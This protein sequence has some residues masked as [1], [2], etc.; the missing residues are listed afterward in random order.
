MLK[1]YTITLIFL[2]VLFIQALFAATDMQPTVF[3]D[4]LEKVPAGMSFEYY[5]KLQNNTGIATDQASTL[6]ITIPEGFTFQNDNGGHGCT[7][8]GA[9]PSDGNGYVECS[10]ASGFAGN[11]YQEINITVLS[12]EDAGVFKSYATV[13]YSGDTN[14][15]NNQ[16][17]TKTTIIES[18]DVELKSI[19]PT[20]TNTF[21]AGSIATF[22]L[23]IANNGP[24]ATSA[25]K[26]T[27]TLPTGLEYS[28]V[29]GASGWSCATSGADLTCERAGTFAKNTDE[30]INLNLRVTAQGGSTIP[31]AGAVS[32]SDTVVDRNR[33]NND[34]NTTIYTTDG[35]DLSISKGINDSELI[36]NTIATFT[37]SAKNNGPQGAREVKVSDTI[38]AGHDFNESNI[39]L[40]SPTDWNCS[41]VGQA[42]SCEYIGNGGEMP[43]GT[44]DTITIITTTPDVSADTDYTNTATIETNLTD[45]MSGNDSGS[46][47]YKVRVDQTDLSVSKSKKMKEDHRDGEPIL[48][49]E[50]MESS[51]SVRN[52]GPRD[53]D[54]DEVIVKDTLDANESYIGFSGSDWDCSESSG[55]VTCIYRKA[56]ANGA[57]TT[58]LKIETNATQGDVSVLNEVNVNTTNTNYPD[59]TPSN[60]NDSDSMEAQEYP[61]SADIEVIKTRDDDDINTSENSFVYTIKIKNNGPAKAKN[62]KFVDAIP[63][64]V[65][66]RNGRDATVLSV[67]SSKPTECS[68]TQISGANVSCTFGEIAVNETVEVNITISGAMEEGTKTNTASAYTKDTADSNRSNNE[69]SIDVNVVEKVDVWIEQSYSYAEYPNPVWAGTDVKLTLNVVNNGPAD[70]QNVKIKNIFDEEIYRIVALPTGCSTDD[71]ITLICDLGDI[72]GTSQKGLTITLRPDHNTTPPDPWDINNTAEVNTTSFET[73][74]TNNYSSGGFLI[75]NGT[76][77]LSIEKDESEDFHEP[78]KYDPDNNAS[79]IIVYKISVVNFGPSEA[80]NVRYIDKL[81][82]VNPDEN[83]TL[84]FMGD[85][86]SPDGSGASFDHCVEPNPNPFDVNSSAPEIHC[87]IGYMAKDDTYE[88]YLVFHVDKAPHKIQGH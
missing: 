7:Y 21:V 24:F 8:S 73:D 67:S 43:A 18:A 47:N 79:N 70:A 52:N 58:E 23:V 63:Q 81:A 26:F 55:V 50:P 87:T 3:E 69:D 4:S 19:T 20:P 27:T 71:N 25:V 46:V 66:A 56:L 44:D 2:N 51:I 28:S 33:T 53:A 35:T 45:P 29:G 1:R 62:V 74:Y 88:R 83:Q 12:G 85:T 30:T 59:W 13:T 9:V 54:P 61:E 31:L 49:G 10:F 72:G 36:E 39:T 77:D 22:E 80:T 76:V 82:Y 6:K 65:E 5:V 57:T 17:N 68:D 48:V 84:T 41:V 15:A 86:S 14:E 78:V 60:N 75:R 16:E 11:S 42:L 64:Y 40:S 34:Q 37:L 32:D 38:P